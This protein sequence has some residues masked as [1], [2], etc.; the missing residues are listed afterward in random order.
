M[1]G[2]GERDYGISVSHQFTRISLKCVFVFY[3]NCYV[4]MNIS[5]NPCKKHDIQ[6][7]IPC[8]NLVHNHMIAI[9]EAIFSRSRLHL[10][11]I[12]VIQFLITTIILT[13]NLL[14]AVSLIA[15]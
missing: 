15:K 12:V 6:A 7:S 13:C 10:F 3:T 4:M 9:S 14:L 2:L 11:M 5:T 1:R 8:L